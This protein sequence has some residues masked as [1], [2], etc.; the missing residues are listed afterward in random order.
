MPNVRETA[1]NILY[2]W[3]IG[4][5]AL[6]IAT[7]CAVPS[8]QTLARAAVAGAHALSAHI[9]AHAPNDRQIAAA[10]A[11]ALSYCN[12]PSYF[13]PLSWV[14]SW[15]SNYGPITQIANDYLGPINNI[16]MPFDT[17]L[18]VC[19]VANHAFTVF[20]RI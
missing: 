1:N 5:A 14:G 2:Y 18:S 7:F 13:Q 17:V 12:S 11:N 10:V 19:N 15:F 9:G 20:N 16:V 3:N 4:S 6:S 8:Q